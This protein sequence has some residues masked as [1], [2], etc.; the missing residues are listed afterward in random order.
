MGGKYSR[1]V[2]SH[3]IFTGK[4]RASINKFIPKE[5]RSREAIGIFA[6]WLEVFND[7]DTQISPCLVTQELFHI[8]TYLAIRGQQG[9]QYRKGTATKALWRAP[10]S[11]H[12]GNDASSPTPAVMNHN[13]C[14]IR[15]F[16]PP[17]HPHL[18]AE[19]AGRFR[20]L[21]P[22][23]DRTLVA[24]RTLYRTFCIFNF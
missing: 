15:D 8:S 23:T 21:G 17:E 10:A 11:L 6:V 2:A 7:T 1:E 24:F 3:E 13:E 12:V 18:A 19:P 9:Q 4:Y 22:S 14:C 5:Y 20:S 16:Q